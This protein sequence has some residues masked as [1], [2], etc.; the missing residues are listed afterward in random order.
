MTLKA[1]HLWRNTMSFDI[2][3]LVKSKYH[4]YTIM[5]VYEIIYTDSVAYILKIETVKKL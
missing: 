1:A 2:R 5:M 3:D 4:D